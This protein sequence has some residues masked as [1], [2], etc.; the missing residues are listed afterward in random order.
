MKT[1]FLLQEL[2]N[3]SWNECLSSWTIIEH[4]VTEE[5]YPK[6]HRHMVVRTFSTCQLS[7]DHWRILVVHTGESIVSAGFIYSSWNSRLVQGVW[8][9][10]YFSGSYLVHTQGSES[11]IRSKDWWFID[12]GLR[13]ILNMLDFNV[14]RGD[15][16]PQFRGGY[17]H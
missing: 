2:V 16:E 12:S 11:D 6:L 4:S 1:L 14:G 10:R 5:R 15:L 3:E 13:E 9:L 7:N 17:W 8:L